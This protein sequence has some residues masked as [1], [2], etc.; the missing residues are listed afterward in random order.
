MI[1]AV[2]GRCRAALAACVLLTLSAFGCAGRTDN[3]AQQLAPAAPAQELRSPGVPQIHPRWQSCANEPSTRPGPDDSK[4][5]TL[6]H[7]TDT[8]QPVAAIICAGGPQ[9]RPD[10]GQ[11][12]V[13]I[14]DRVNDVATLLTALRLPDEPPLFEPADDDDSPI[15]ACTMDLV[16]P[17][18]LV[19]LDAEG[20][21]VRPGIPFDACGKPRVEV[22]TAVEKA[23]RTRIATRVLHEIESAEAAATGCSDEWADMVWVYGT[24]SAARPTEDLAKLADDGSPVRACIYRVPAGEQRSDKPRGEVVSRNLLPAERWAAIRR[25]VQA[26]GPVQ[27]C[28]TPASHFALLLPGEIYVELDGC[29]RILA[30][31]APRGDGTSSDTLRQAPAALPALLTTP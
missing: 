10:G 12:A 4:A 20:R 26:A 3:T 8:F 31:A 14:E 27:A 1:A 16:V 21:W 9:R 24:D 18:W 6:P 30:P 29:R 23:Q 15:T 22:L 13:A 17:P 5:L 2:T 19:L 25:H 7:L 11:D 28:S